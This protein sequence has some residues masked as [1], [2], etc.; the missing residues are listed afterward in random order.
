ME[1]IKKIKKLKIDVIP[2]LNGWIGDAEFGMRQ[3][4]KYFNNEKKINVLEIGCGLGILLSCIKEK[5]PNLNVEG[6]EPYK[7]GFGRLKIQ[8]KILPSTIE[9]NNLKFEKFIPKKKY[10]IIYSVNVFEH[11]SNWKL[12]LKK[13]NEWLNPEGLN[14]ILCPNY[15]FPYESHFK[16]P[17]IIN[18]KL[19]YSIFKKKIK[20][21]EKENKSLGLWDSLNFIKMRKIKSYCLNNR[22]KF[23]YCNTVFDDVIKR[24][25]QDQDFKK[26]QK[27][28]GTCAK[29]L[30]KIGIIKLLNKKVF[31]FFH[32]YMKLEIT[33][34][35]FLVKKKLFKESSK[36]K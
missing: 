32:P 24:I 17:I 19:T 9:I 10:D 3:L 36:I 16:I 33:K 26:R 34:D 14:I 20:K 30:K 2:D 5:Y 7:G 1:I 31:Y 18:K 12:Y 4:A 8:K 35:K 27:F 11:L 22:L 28:V 23:T 29:Y 13:T 21:Y 25:E 6:I 15:S